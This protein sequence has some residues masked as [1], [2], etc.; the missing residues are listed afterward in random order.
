LHLLILVFPSPSCPHIPHLHLPRLALGGTCLL[1]PPPLLVPLVRLPATS[2]SQDIHPQVVGIGTWDSA[3]MVALISGPSLVIAVYPSTLS[4]RQSP[5]CDSPVCVCAGASPRCTAREENVSAKSPVVCSLGLARAGPLQRS[6]ASRRDG[7]AGCMAEG[8]STGGVF[9]RWLK[10][11]C[12]IHTRYIH[13]CY[14]HTRYIHTCYIHTCYIHT[15]YIH[16][17][18]PNRHVH[19]NHHVAGKDMCVGFLFQGF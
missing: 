1:Q 6:T 13:T 12:Y 15:C 5:L 9:T 2:S 10:Y 8:G 19:N 3:C 4:L 14:I 7:S 17:R 16:T 11:T 18:A